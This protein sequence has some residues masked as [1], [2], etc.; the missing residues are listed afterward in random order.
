[1]LCCHQCI[2]SLPLPS[3]S[4]PGG[5]CRI[6]RAAPPP[7]AMTQD[8]DLS[9]V[10]GHIPCQALQCSRRTR[11]PV[12]K[13]DCQLLAAGELTYSTM[14]KVRDVTP[15]ARTIWQFNDQHSWVAWIHAAGEAY[16]GA[17]CARTVTCSGLCYSWLMWDVSCASQVHGNGAW[18]LKLS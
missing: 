13:D 12:G 6:D 11:M 1:M 9:K 2:H 17:L 15:W 10:Q 4:A 8:L 3:V 5:W 14:A 18:F 16:R 7:P